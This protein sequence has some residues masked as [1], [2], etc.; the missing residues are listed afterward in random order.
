MKVVIAPDSFKESMTA[1]QAAESIERG[2]RQ[3]FGNELQAELIP[4]ADGGEGTTTSMADA[5][6]GTMYETTVTGPN[7]TPVKAGYALM[8]DGKT[9]VI[10]MAEASGLALIPKE[11]RNPLHATSYGTGELIQAAL[12]KGAG[13]IILGIGGSATNDGGAGMFQALGGRLIDA[14][15]E[16]LAPGG[17]ALARLTHIDASQLDPRLQ[18]TDIITACDVNNPLTGRNGAS[19]VYGP[20]KGAD[21][22]MTK[23]LDH[24]L[25]HYA[26]IIETQ[27]GK[28][29]DNLPGAGAAGGLGAGL[30]AFLNASLEPGID[31]VLKE[32][33]FRERIQEADLVITGEGKI[34][35]QTING[36]T[37]VG[38]A[39]AANGVKSIP[40][41]AFCGQLGEGYEEVYSHRITAV[42]SI[43][44][45][46]GSVETAM[47]NGV[48][49]I[50]KLARNVA[51]VWKAARH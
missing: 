11:E 7:G 10:E 40:V 49:Y 45:G 35:H 8:G 38:V 42:F 14:F 9:A 34:D 15:G 21:E 44:P 30:K 39:E 29:V 16:E 5:L 3:G 41:L 31:I 4:M 17:E 26:E 37:P 19:A 6:N 1:M 12:D 24:A 20:Q 33:H 2:F 46:P 28:N 18:Q 27:L 50:E 51:A 25:S 36:K 13:K 32:T 48:A 47:E 22:D 43:M 23:T